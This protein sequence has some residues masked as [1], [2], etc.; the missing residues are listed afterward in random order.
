MNHALR[1]KT[2]YIIDTGAPPFLP[3]KRGEEERRR[4]GTTALAASG[5]SV[6][7][8]ARARQRPT[9]RG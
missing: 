3:R 8:G 9:A 7:V 2:G 6:Q 5:G 1:P 4:V